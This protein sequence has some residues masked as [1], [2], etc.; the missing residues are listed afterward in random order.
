ME[1]E[2]QRAVEQAAQQMADR[3]SFLRKAAVG[4]AG[5]GM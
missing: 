3:R 4:V 5:G 1:G 2:V